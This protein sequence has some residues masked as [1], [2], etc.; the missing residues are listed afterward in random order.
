MGLPAYRPFER[1]ADYRKGYRN[2]VPGNY[3]NQTLV[4]G[5]EPKRAATG[6]TVRKN[7]VYNALPYPGIG[8][9]EVRIFKP[10]KR[11]QQSGDTRAGAI[12]GNS[13]FQ[14]NSYH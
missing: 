5:S 4:C 2:N 13:T 10:E 3:N 11:H 7:I 12:P 1:L 8:M 6:C 14:R 9:P